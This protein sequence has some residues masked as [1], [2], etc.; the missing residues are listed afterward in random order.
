[1]QSFVHFFVQGQWC[2][3]I[4]FNFTKKL[5]IDGGGQLNLLKVDPPPP[6]GFDRFYVLPDKASYFR[7]SLSKI[8]LITGRC[9][10]LS[11]VPPIVVL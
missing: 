8:F 9:V 11:A 1:M 3:L 7:L 4:S 2:D 10:A 6:I 5:G